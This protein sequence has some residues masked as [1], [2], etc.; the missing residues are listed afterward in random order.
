MKDSPW[1]IDLYRC[2]AITLNSHLVLMLMAQV[3]RRIIGFGVHGSD[4]DDISPLVASEEQAAALCQTYENSKTN[5]YF[6]VKGRA[7]EPHV[8]DNSMF[9]RYVAV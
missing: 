7:Q 8:I 2:D 6:A 9:L 5:I 1:S 4:V 3:T